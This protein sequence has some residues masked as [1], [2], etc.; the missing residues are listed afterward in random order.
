MPGRLKKSAKCRVCGRPVF[1]V[2][3]TW[4]SSRRVTFEYI[5]ESRRLKPCVKVTSWRTGEK[6]QRE[7]DG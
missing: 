6:W 3:H 1:A 5:H 2:F 4:H 7:E